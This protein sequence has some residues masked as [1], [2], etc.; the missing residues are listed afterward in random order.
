MSAKPVAASAVLARKLGAAA[1]AL[2]AGFEGAT[3]RRRPQ[4]GRVSQDH[5]CCRS[6]S[7]NKL[8][9]EDALGSGSPR[10][11]QMPGSSTVGSR[12]SNCKRARLLVS[13]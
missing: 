11:V 9:C 7:R 12:A 13:L 10:D 1:A 6:G 5:G 3:M 2:R 8:S 4:G